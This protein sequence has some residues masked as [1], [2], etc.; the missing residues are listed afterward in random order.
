MQLSQ[1]RFRLRVTR[2]MLGIATGAAIMLASTALCA[3]EP[4]LV[5]RF[6]WE[7]VWF[8]GHGLGL[9]PIA[10]HAEKLWQMFD[11]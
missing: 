5:P 7:C 1:F 9:M 6:C 11:E 2:H 8:M 4:I 10:H 3:I